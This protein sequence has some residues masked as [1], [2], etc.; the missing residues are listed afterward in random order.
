M[1]CCS[2]MLGVEH[3]TSRGSILLDFY[4]RYICV[5]I[6][7]TGVNPKRFLDAFAWSDT[8]WRLGELKSQVWGNKGVRVLPE[9]C[10]QLMPCCLDFTWSDAHCL[11]ASCSEKCIASHIDHRSLL[12]LTCVIWMQA[13]LDHYAQQCDDNHTVSRRS[14]A[15]Q[16]CRQPMSRCV[17]CICLISCLF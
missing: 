13:L 12:G 15:M 16:F 2:R 8:T 17:L 11:F 14:R 5:K 10:F 1:S 4:G 7:P 6:M 9:S 3:L